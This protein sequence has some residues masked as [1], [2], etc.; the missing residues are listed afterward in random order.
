MIHVSLVEASLL[1]LIS[2]T[3]AA[4]VAW[5]LGGAPGPPGIVCH[6]VLISGVVS[7][8]L[9]VEDGWRNPAILWMAISEM[10]VIANFHRRI[11]SRKPNRR[12]TRAAVVDRHA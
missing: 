11:S 8:A 3:G 2:V 5:R 10:A 7:L 9:L 4:L 12:P 1:G 6:G